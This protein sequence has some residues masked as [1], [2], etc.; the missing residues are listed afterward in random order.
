LPSCSTRGVH[1]FFAFPEN[2]SI[3]SKWLKVCR[4]QNIGKYGKLCTKHFLNED[5]AHNL[6]LNE[7]A[8]PSKHLE[9]SSKDSESE[10]SE[11]NEKIENESD[12][13]IE[14]E[15]I[16]NDEDIESDEK[17]ENDEKMESE[18]IESYDEIENDHEIAIDE[19]IESDEIE[20]YYEIEEEIESNEKIESDDEIENQIKDATIEIIENAIIRDYPLENTETYFEVPQLSK[21]VKISFGQQTNMKKAYKCSI[22]DERFLA[23]SEVLVH[24]NKVHKNKCLICDETF[25]SKD[26]LEEHTNNTHH[27]QSVQDDLEEHTNNTHHLQPVQ[28]NYKFQTYKPK[29]ICQF[30]YK[31]Y[32]HQKKRLRGTKCGEPFNS[33]E[34]LISHLKSKHNSQKITAGN[35]ISKVS[36][37]PVQGNLL[38]GIDNKTVRRKGILTCLLTYVLFSVTLF[39]RKQNGL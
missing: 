24:L 16:E 15:K 9:L 29:T 5:F 38:K 17:N 12:E 22:C 32:D 28:G 30:Q 7:N 6:A 31:Y 34:E 20:N 4:L 26:D 39:I 37:V 19:I 13:K 11:N 35:P 8:I 2:E 33:R 25:K 36:S 21:E 1:V 23:I 10:E 18:K 14:S 27:I 3:R